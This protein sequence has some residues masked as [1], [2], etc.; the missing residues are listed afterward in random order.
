MNKTRNYGIDLLRVFA[1]MMVVSLHVLRHGGLLFGVERGSI[2]Y[3]VVWLMEAA[4]LC[5]VNTY[6]LISGYVGINSKP[7]CSK[8]IL[9]WMQV[10]FYTIIITF[11]YTLKYS[12]QITSD[13]WRNAIF[14]IFSKQYWYISAYFGLYLLLPC[15]HWIIEKISLKKAKIMGLVGFIATSILPSFLQSDPFNISSGYSM[16][17]L[18]I[19][20]IVGAC[21]K[22]FNF[23]ENWSKHSLALLYGIT[24]FTAWGSKLVLDVTGPKVEGKAYDMIFMNYI[25]PTIIIAAIALVALFAKINIANRVFIKFIS[26]ISPATLGVYIIHE[27][28]FVKENIIMGISLPFVKASNSLVMMLEVIF[29]VLLIYFCCT[30]IELFRLKIFRLLHIEEKCRVLDEKIEK[31]LEE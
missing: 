7:R 29:S 13:A 2:R 19:L 24:V 14:P 21:M 12:D 10:V 28:V 3:M 26:I 25:S 4:A 11:L 18:C 15:I 31:W 27:Q 22:K 23:F 16:L 20:Y 17:W 5:A 30:F 8:L 1:M 6:A 9:L